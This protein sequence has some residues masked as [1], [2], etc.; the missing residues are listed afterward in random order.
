MADAYGMLVFTKS[1]DCKFHGAKLVKVL[2]QYRWNNDDEPWFYCSENK[3]FYLHKNSSVQYPTVFPEIEI[4]DEEFEVAS[5]EDLCKEISPFLKSGWIEIACSSNEKQRYVTFESLRISADGKASRKQF[6][7][8]LFTGSEDRRE[9]VDL[10]IY[11]S[12]LKRKQI[13]YQDY[14]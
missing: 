13:K 10:S 4:N 11:N 14:A 2:N 9:D 6:T 5:L 7:S 3:Y 12:S 8:G 1:K